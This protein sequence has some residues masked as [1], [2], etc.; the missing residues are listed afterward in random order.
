[1]ARSSLTSAEDPQVSTTPVTVVTGYLGSGKTTLLKHILASPWGRRYAVIVNEF[2]DLGIDGDLLRCDQE[3]VITLA[4]GCLCCKVRGDLMR[5]L[6]SLLSRGVELDGIV[7]ETSGLADPGPVIQT[8]FMD[9]QI[10]SRTRL[11]AIVTVTDARHL[12]AQLVDAP[13]IEAQ[14]AAADLVLINKTDLVSP[15]DLDR[16]LSTIRELNRF[17]EIRPTLHSSLPIAD[18]LDRRAFDLNRVIER[19]PAFADGPSRHSGT[20]DS[21][22]LRA[23]RPLQMDRFLRWIDSLTALRGDDLLR[24]KGILNFEG[25]DRPFVFQAVH[26]IMDGDFQREASAGAPDSKLVI[27]GRHLDRER[28]RRNFAGCQIALADH[29][30]GPGQPPADAPRPHTL[31]PRRHPGA[32]KGTYDYER[33]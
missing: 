8:F 23:Y 7:V 5:S 31:T 4:S 12:H 9:P 22:G 18:V 10:S 6:K 27:I 25:Q 1:M 26:R 32:T 30:E 3:E 33:R 21:I 11:D 24:I 20:I 29:P 2:S 16:L 14:V 15:G 17:A 19:V 28:L 13:E